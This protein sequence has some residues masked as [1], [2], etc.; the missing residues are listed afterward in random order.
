MSSA[1]SSIPQAPADAVIWP[2]AERQAQFEAWLASLQAEFGLVPKSL[3]LASAD[4]SFRRY[5]RLDTADGATRIAMDAPPDK[6]NCRPFVEVAALMQSAG[7]NVPRVLNW[8]EAHGF[9]LLEDLGRQTLM[10]HAQALLGIDPFN[11]P[12][13]KQTLPSSSE[14][15]RVQA[16]FRQATEQLIVWQQASKPGVLPAYDDAVLQRELMLF[17]DWYIAKHKGI[18]L[19]AAQTASMQT[20]FERIKASN[21]AAPQVYVHRDFMPRNLMMPVA[22]SERLGVLDFQDA[23]YGPVTYDIACLMRDAFTSWDDELVLDTSIR[24]WEQARKAGLVTNGAWGSWADDFGEFWK[25]VDFMALQRHLK[26]AG[27]FARLTHRDG[28]ARYVADAPRFT[29]YIRDTCERYRELRPL[30][31]VI[32]SVEGMDA[33][34]THRRAYGL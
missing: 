22:E 23:L 10:Q 5:L 29:A 28:K 15:S 16:L 11:P 17:P 8:H 19:T 6:E 3:R 25:A 20:V 27:I 33:E 26:V 1:A 24:Y 21:L 30:L 14:G 2:S 18:T 12:F 9:L 7:L 4:A 34:T 32:D 13:A 31:H